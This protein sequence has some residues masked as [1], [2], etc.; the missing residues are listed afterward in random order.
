MK[1]LVSKLKIDVNNHVFLKNPDSSDLGKKI[2]S[3]S[4]DLINEIGFE[5]FTF[6]KLA[7]RIKT[8]EASIY[9]YF[10]SKHKLL[11]YLSCWYWG[12]LEYRLVFNT[13]NIKEPQERLKRA[14]ITLTEKVDDSF[15][16]PFINLKKL[17][18]IIISESAKAYLT[19]E[20]D[21]ENNEGVFEAY[22]NLIKRVSDIVKEINPAYQYSHMLVSTIIEG[23]HHQHFFSE[24]LPALTDKINDRD[25]IADF[26][27]ELAVKSIK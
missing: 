26:Y 22:K 8:T 27:T 10:E 14:V 2:L 1:Q 20:V 24:H 16:H 17:S 19:K 12:W 13:A 6:R 3:G 4:I 5:S 15:E 7:V 11:L 23:S 21:I 9:R 18:S 25:V